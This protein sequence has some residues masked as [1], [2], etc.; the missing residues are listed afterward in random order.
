MEAK[1]ELLGKLPLTEETKELKE[2][3]MRELWVIRGVLKHSFDEEILVKMKKTYKDVKIV[4]NHYDLA[5][6]VPFKGTKV[7]RP[8]GLRRLL[9]TLSTP[10][11][12][13]GIF[14]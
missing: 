12:N 1:I 8:P 7:V 14:K 11:F 10:I 5:A 3:L 9:R 4:P 13:K 6:L 2:D